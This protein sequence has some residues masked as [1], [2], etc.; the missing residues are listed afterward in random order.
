MVNRDN[1]NQLRR[2]RERETRRREQAGQSRSDES[3]DDSSSDSSGSESVSMTDAS[4]TSREVPY[5]D[6]I[7]NPSHEIAG[8]KNINE[9]NEEQ[10]LN[11]NIEEVADGGA[12]MPHGGERTKLQGRERV[13]TEREGHDLP[14][15]GKTES[16]RK[17]GVREIG[18][19]DVLGS[20]SGSRHFD[21]SD[22][23]KENNMEGEGRRDEGDVSNSEH[24]GN[25]RTGTDSSEGEGESES[26]SDSINGSGD[27]SDDDSESESDEIER[28]RESTIGRNKQK[29]RDAR[30]EE[31]KDDDTAEGSSS[32]SAEMVQQTSNLHSDGEVDSSE[33]SDSSEEPSLPRNSGSSRPTA[34]GKGLKNPHMK[35]IRAQQK[36][37]EPCPRDDM[38]TVTSK[39][40]KG[41]HAR[42]SEPSKFGP[43]RKKN[44]GGGVDVTALKTVPSASIRTGRRV[45]TKSMGKRDSPSRRRDFGLDGGK[46]DPYAIL[47][48]VEHCNGTA[49]IKGFDQEY[50]FSSRDWRIFEESI[51]SQ[52]NI[53]DNVYLTLK[54]AF[55]E[56]DILEE[57]CEKLGN[58]KKSMQ[59][60]SA[61][62][63]E[64]AS[65][66]M[67][68]PSRQPAPLKVSKTL[69]TRTKNRIHEKRAQQTS[70]GE[71]IMLGDVKRGVPIAGHGNVPQHSR[72]KRKQRSP[73]TR[74]E[75]RKMAKLMS[76]HL[77]KVQR[78]RLVKKPTPTGAAV[79]TA[80]SKSIANEWPAPK[81]LS[82]SHAEKFADEETAL[83]K[84]HF[85]K[86]ME[87]YSK[88]LSVPAERRNLIATQKEFDKVFRSIVQ[89]AREIVR[90]YKYEKWASER[91][92]HE[93]IRRVT[94]EVRDKMMAIFDLTKISLKKIGSE[95][96]PEITYL[97]NI[98]ECGEYSK[99]LRRLL[100]LFFD[101]V[102]ADEEE[103]YKKN[104]ER[105]QRKRPSLKG[106][107][108]RP[109]DISSEFNGNESFTSSRNRLTPYVDGMSKHSRRP[110][111]RLST[112]PGGSNLNALPSPLAQRSQ[113]SSDVGGTYKKAGRSNGG[114]SIR[115]EGK[116]KS[117]TEIQ[118]DLNITYLRQIHAFR[119]EQNSG[120]DVEPWLS[121]EVVVDYFWNA[122]VAICIKTGLKETNLGA[123]M[124]KLALDIEHE[125]VIFAARSKTPRK[126]RGVYHVVTRYVCCILEDIGSNVREWLLKDDPIFEWL[127]ECI[128]CKEG[129]T[130]GLVN[131]CTQKI[132]EARI[133]QKEAV[134][135]RKKSS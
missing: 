55:K 16:A 133:R 52:V 80:N 38:V 29:K 23:Q 73:G 3:S 51:R 113:G 131:E 18:K 93:E 10:K 8:G 64:E 26:G 30:T 95:L 72:L 40:L 103:K 31:D 41:L 126:E 20:L 11:K 127:K 75:T 116:N 125:I 44:S 115:R 112:A 54:E 92:N 48:E 7:E 14:S 76:D 4:S 109:T 71:L 34:G 130:H 90:S 37:K 42:G 46:K 77:A 106:E 56:E 110:T 117:D 17:S 135:K 65:Q 36:G 35:G 39:G 61:L 27:E 118:V 1:C 63:A 50:E 6:L 33:S 85:D 98:S 97:L 123:D 82:S 86:W 120:K 101:I 99:A 122:L 15:R 67:G 68:S 81:P 87:A 12:T 32:S 100:M 24:S 13:E 114:R 5:A 96:M 22:P 28:K 59:R 134:S 91:P 129:G 121:K 70:V 89:K 102:L 45:S 111:P 21:V 74:P 9:F 47:P 132:Y 49:Y 58:F 25:S 88:C 94:E 84:E 83:R 124:K 105:K 53:G 79:N 69:D 119:K 66:V 78:E 104:L 107:P 57:F 43:I 108:T 19:D 60:K 2:E 128:A 62:P